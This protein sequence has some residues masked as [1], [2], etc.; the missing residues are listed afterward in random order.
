MTQSLIVWNALIKAAAEKDKTIADIVVGAK[1]PPSA[2]N[3]L[4]SMVDDNSSERT[5]EQAK[6]KIEELSMKIRN[7]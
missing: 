2:W 7:L 1:A 3:I 5:K 4:K 6:K